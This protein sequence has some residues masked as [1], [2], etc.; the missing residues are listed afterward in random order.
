MKKDSIKHTYI[1]GYKETENIKN[2]KGNEEFPEKLIPF[3]KITSLKL[4]FGK[5][6]K[7]SGNSLIAIE[8]KYQN[9]ASGKRIEKGI[10]GASITEQNIEVKELEIK[11]GDYLSKFNIGFEENIHH[12][13]FTTKN[14]DYIEF[15]TIDK[16]TEKRSVNDLNEGDNVIINIRGFYSGNGVRGLGCDYMSKKDFFFN[17]F[18]DILRLNHRIKMEK[19]VDKNT[20]EKYQKMMSNLNIEMKCVLRICFLPTSLFASILKYL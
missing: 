5:S 16:E 11:T 17:R 18:F 8:V 15:G 4:W 7:S 1:F 10:Q 19:S 14:G 2:I 3:T 9:F 6:L 12:I 20:D 13:K